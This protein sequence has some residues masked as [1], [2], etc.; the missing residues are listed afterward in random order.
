[1]TTPKDCGSSDLCNVIAGGFVLAATKRILYLWDMVK[2]SSRILALLVLTCLAAGAKDLPWM[3]PTTITGR[4]ILN[5]AGEMRITSGDIVV[6]SESQK[7]PVK[8]IPVDAIGG[9]ARYE[10]AKKLAAEGKIVTLHGDFERLSTRGSEVLDSE[11][12]F[13]IKAF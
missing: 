5:K 3:K 4:L 8:N 13:I 7:Y 12:I 6:R 10:D 1:L 2:I 9:S 11:I